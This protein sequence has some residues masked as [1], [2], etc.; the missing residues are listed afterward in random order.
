MAEGVV[1]VAAASWWAVVGPLVA[2]VHS[3][4]VVAAGHPS[5]V[6]AVGHPSPV[7]AVGHSSPVAAVGHSSPVAAVGHSSFVA[8]VGHSS[9]VAEIFAVHQVLNLVPECPADHWDWLVVD[10]HYYFVLDLPLLAQADIVYL[11]LG[12]HRGRTYHWVGGYLVD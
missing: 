3:S 2:L 1:V 5:L 8:A 12:Q 9:P 11:D 6:V 10:T 7:A 4:P